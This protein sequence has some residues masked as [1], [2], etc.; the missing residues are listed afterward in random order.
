MLG[1]IAA[2]ELE[3]GLLNSMAADSTVVTFRRASSHLHQ[4]YDST[5]ATPN[6]C[7]FSWLIDSAPMSF[8]IR[9]PL[10]LVH[11]VSRVIMPSLETDGS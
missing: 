3:Y 11:Q 4:S 10:E 5:V 6:G 7:D 2:K 9:S 1:Y 8:N